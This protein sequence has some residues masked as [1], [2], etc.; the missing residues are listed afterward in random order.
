M[1]VDGYKAIVREHRPRA[2]VNGVGPNGIITFTDR[3]FRSY[4]DFMTADEEAF[5]LYWFAMMNRGVM[6]AHHYGG[7]VWTV[8]IVHT[9]ED[10]EAH[11]GAFEAV[12]P[13]F[14]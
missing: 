8:S 7:D 5:R 1:L 11:L 12:A 3:P 14:R 9:K 10:I 4:R 2:Q 13:M 6:P